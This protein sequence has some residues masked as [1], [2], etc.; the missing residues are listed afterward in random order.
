MELLENFI[1]EREKNGCPQPFFL[2]SM[3]LYLNIY[4]RTVKK[5][6]GQQ[7]YIGFSAD[8]KG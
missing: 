3:L 6:F 4:I 2:C 5:F 8:T 1:P 7:Y